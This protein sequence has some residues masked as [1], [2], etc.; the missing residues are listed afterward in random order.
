MPVQTDASPSVFPVYNFPSLLR[1]NFFVHCP[2]D[3]GLDVIAS[4]LFID[5]HLELEAT[6]RFREPGN[7][8]PFCPN[9]RIF[10]LRGMFFSQVG[11][12]LGRL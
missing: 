2:G 9:V 11:K 10:F 1:G 4:D 7:V 12:F 6:L 8:L 3:S 5:A